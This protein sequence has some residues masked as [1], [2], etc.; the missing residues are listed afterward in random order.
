[1]RRSVE[2]VECFSLSALKLGR[3]HQSLP[4]KRGR[5]CHRAKWALFQR[6]WVRQLP[7]VLSEI[8]EAV[9]PSPASASRWQ[10]DCNEQSFANLTSIVWILF[11]YY[12]NIAIPD[13]SEINMTKV[14]FHHMQ[15]VTIS[16]FISSFLLNLGQGPPVLEIGLVPLTADFGSVWSSK[17]R[18]NFNI[19]N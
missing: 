13:I 11:E 14:H 2:E 6:L 5:G 10:R 7:I 15:I 8:I 17:K 12:R 18:I 19:F 3:V 16:Y 1:M 9:P 4:N